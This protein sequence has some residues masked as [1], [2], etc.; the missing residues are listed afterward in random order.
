MGSSIP[1]Q[2]ILAT[3]HGIEKK[4]FSNVL[5]LIERQ[6]MTH[7][8]STESERQW[9]S[10][11]AD[12]ATT[13]LQESTRKLI[14]TYLEACGTHGSTHREAEIEL[15]IRGDT[16]RPAF[17]ELEKMGWLVNSGKVRKNPISNL[18]AIVWVTAGLKP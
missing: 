5:T 1:G 3:T 9:T 10:E 7:D 12:E 16:L 15:A 14:H 13:N 17:R 11:H 6:K 8:H 2:V 4:A 18:P